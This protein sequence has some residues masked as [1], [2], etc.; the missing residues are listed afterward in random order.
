[1]GDTWTKSRIAS[2]AGKRIVV[3]GGNSGIGWYAALE[4]ARAGA[5]VTIASRNA[6][7]VADAAARIRALVKGAVIIE[8]KLDL[9]DPASVEEFASQQLAD[10]RPLDVLVNNAGVMALP[11]RRLSV[12][13]HEMQFST[14]VLGPYRLTGLLLPALLRAPEPRVVTVASGSHKAAGQVPLTD[15]DS[16]ESYHPIRVYA[17]TK[18]ANLLFT[19]ELQRRAGK[20]L[21]AVACHP[22]AAHSSLGND[23]SLLMKLAIFS[24]YPIIQS[25]EMGAEPILMAATLPNAEPGGYYGPAGFLELRG[26]P[27]KAVPDARALDDT[28]ARLLFEN[29]ETISG[30]RY[31]F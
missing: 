16:V 8:A 25:T 21:L 31:T 7:K 29:L 23:T 12:D 26:H 9:S 19:H 1:M 5:E 30:I 27:A 15:L 11:D 24:I 28:A 4:L 2:Q 3:T 18:M 13:G 22:G 10:E 17:K 14:N 6:S 20:K